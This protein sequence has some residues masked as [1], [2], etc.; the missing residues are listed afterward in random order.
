[1]SRQST[2]FTSAE[3]DYEQAV[4]KQIAEAKAY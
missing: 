2:N 1:M 3:E 4:K